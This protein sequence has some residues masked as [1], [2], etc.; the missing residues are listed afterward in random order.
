[1]TAAEPAPPMPAVNRTMVTVTVMLASILQTLDNTIANVA[2]PKMMGSLSAT[3]DQMTWVLTSYIVAAAV[4]TP[5]TGW[6]AGQFGRKRLFLA[7]VAGFTVASMLCGLA[8][9]LPQIV[10]FRFL[11]GLAGAALVPMSQA[12]LF[13]I[14]PPERHGRA[15]AAWGQGVLIGPMI[16]PIL[17]G[18]LTDNYSWRWVFYI[19]LPLGILAFLGVLAFLPHGETRKS[20]FDFFGF[21]LLALFVVSLQLGLDRGPLM[22]WFGS[23]EIWIEFTLAALALYLFAVHSATT[24]HPFFRPALFKDRNYVS[25]NV[26]IFVVGVVMFAT[27]ALLPPLLQQLLGYPVYEAGLLTAPRSVGTLAAMM[28]VGP[29]IGKVPSR[30]IIGAGFSLTA[31]SLWQMTQFSPEMSGAPIV[32][33][34]LVQGFGTGLAYVPMATI[35]FASLPGNLRNEGSALFSL[36]RNIGSSIGISAVQALFVRNTQIVHASLVE[37]V[38]PYNLANQN[39]QLAAALSSHSGMAAFN[40]VATGQA[41][42]VAYLDDFYLMFFL[43]LLTLPMLLMVREARRGKKVPQVAVE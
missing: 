34:G 6:L 16:G 4:M 15:M 9:T 17:G 42:M 23:T 29:L 13:D 3:Q 39:P 41:A 40:A 7:S 35:A 32:W 36:T 11:Q 18:W 26:F 33:S 22:D 14:N 12:V 8:Q 10:L 5:V 30:L 21:A 25:G 43:T 38:T 1:M 24:A 19:N 27:L 2:L 28:L 31:I 20:R 37:H